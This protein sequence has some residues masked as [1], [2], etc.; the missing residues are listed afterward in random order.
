MGAFPSSSYIP[1]LQT[2]YFLE[3]LFSNEKYM[4]L[5]ASGVIDRNTLS[6]VASKGDSIHI[7]KLAQAAPFVRCDVTDTAAATGTRISSNAGKLP[8][9]RDVSINTLTTH[10]A[11][12][13][14]ENFDPM[15]ATSA[16]NQMAK[17]IIKQVDGALKGSLGALAT[18]TK[19]LGSNALTVQGVRQAKAKLG[20]QGQNLHTMLVHSKVW[21]DLVYDLIQ[22]YK[23]MGITS[24]KIIEEGKLDTIMGIRNIVISDDLVPDAGA[25]S[26]AGDDIYHTY[27]LGS[28]SIYESF[29]RIIGVEEFNDVRVPSTMRFV[30]FSMDYVAGPRGLAFT[31]SDN[32]IDADFANSSNWAPRTEDHRNI[33]VAQVTSLGGVNA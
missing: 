7:P 18:H 12:R 2:G 27:L 4:Q 16:G 3:G 17:R 21:Y 15:L 23:Y 28:A 14:G 6:E 33:L 1:V 30:K 5:E 24:G 8:V 31:G 25:T 22:N 11:L 20:D 9:L 13:T 10:D 32:P 29:Q 19:A 26:S